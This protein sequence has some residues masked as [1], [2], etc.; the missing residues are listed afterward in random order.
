[1]QAVTGGV[2]FQALPKQ[3][4]QSLRVLGDQDSSVGG[5]GGRAGPRSALPNLLCDS[6][7]A[8]PLWAPA[9]SSNKGQREAGLAD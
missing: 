8:P 5:T 7:P 9:A 4:L 1:M 3:K 6:G 2:D